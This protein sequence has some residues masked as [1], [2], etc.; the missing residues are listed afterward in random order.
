MHTCLVVSIILVAMDILNTHRNFKSIIPSFTSAEDISESI[1]P[2]L[3]Y[4]DMFDRRTSPWEMEHFEGDAL[5]KFEIDLEQV[6]RLY[7]IT[8]CHDAFGGEYEILARL[9]YRGKSAYVNLVASCDFTGFECQGGGYIYISFN[10]NV[11]TRIMLG[12]HH[13]HDLIY[14]SLASDGV[15][16]EEQTEYDCHAARMWQSVPL[17]KYLC[18]LAIYKHK[19]CLQPVYT[20]VLPKALIGSVE[21]FLK[22]QETKNAFED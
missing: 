2:A 3:A 12:D 22:L 9:D 5:E 15:N 13:K 19:E 21:E 20:E 4:Q 10:A 14:E 18:H 11:F 1:C 17:L 7:H 16:V 8:A 6:D